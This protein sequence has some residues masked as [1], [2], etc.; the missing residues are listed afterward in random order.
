[1]DKATFDEFVGGVPA[2]RATPNMTR[3]KA[4]MGRVDGCALSPDLMNKL[5]SVRQEIA[6]N[7][8]PEQCELAMRQLISESGVNA[9]PPA[10]AATSLTASGP[11]RRA[12]TTCLAMST[13]LAW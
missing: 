9:P 2:G 7:V 13:P 4:L 1:M 5:E 6:D 3:V 11:T 10:A 8:P 12:R